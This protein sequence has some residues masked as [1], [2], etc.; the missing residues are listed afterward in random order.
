M[1]ALTDEATALVGLRSKP[2]QL[3]GV[4]PLCTTSCAAWAF[5]AR[6]NARWMWTLEV[7]AVVVSH[8][9]RPCH[10]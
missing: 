9:V 6:P 7:A 10:I 5:S 3:G 8:S 4:D 1:T 2:T